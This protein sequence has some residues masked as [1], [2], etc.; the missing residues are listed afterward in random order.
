FCC[1]DATANPY[2]AIAAVLLAGV[3]GV[4]R[5]L[6]PPV[7]GDKP[8]GAR[9]PNC[10]ESAL[11]GLEG[12]RGFLTKGGAF[13]DR[14]I[15]AW[16]ADRWKRHILPVRSRPHPWE[17]SHTDQCGSPRGGEASLG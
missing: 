1:P 12:D 10:L 7:D 2:L 9:I 5:R 14:L 17:L 16:I 11:E 13:S 6:E 4:E 15:D 3:D 8:M